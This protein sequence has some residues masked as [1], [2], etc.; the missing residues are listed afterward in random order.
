M[1]DGCN[2]RTKGSCRSGFRGVTTVDSTKNHS[3]TRTEAAFS[4]AIPTVS[5]RTIVLS[6]PVSAAGTPSTTVSNSATTGGVSAC[7]GCQTG[8]RRTTF[9]GYL[10]THSPVPIQE[11]GIKAKGTACGGDPNT[12]SMG[13][14]GWVITSSGHSTGVGK[15]AASGYDRT[16]T[17]RSSTTMVYREPSY[18]LGS[19]TGSSPAS[20]GSR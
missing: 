2:V 13:P 5:T 6:T 9:T 14:K 4:T 12:A 10:L 3:L 17:T 20:T 7:L 1:E 16:A 19:R 11:E 15:P 18:L 8:P